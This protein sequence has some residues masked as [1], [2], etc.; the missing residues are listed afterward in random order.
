MSEFFKT[1]DL[2]EAAYIY[3]L[4]GKFIKLE[5]ENDICWFVFDN[6]ILCSKLSSEYWSKQGKVVGKDYSESIRTLKDLIFSKKRS[7]NY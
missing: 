1:R 7:F 3:C 2:Y 6:Q 5:Q 4:E